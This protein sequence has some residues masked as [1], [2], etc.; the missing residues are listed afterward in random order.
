MKMER[1]AAMIKEIGGYFE[2]ESFS[3]HDFYCNLIALNTAR[4]ALAYVIKAKKISKVYIPRYLCDSVRTFLRLIS[5]DYELYSIDKNFRPI[6]STSLNQHECIYIV[7]Y[8]GQLNN[9]SIEELKITHGRI[10]LDNTHSFFQE[11]IEGIDTIYSCRKYFGVPDGAYL[12]TIEE[13]D[14]QLE[15][16]VSSNRLNH[17]IG[18]FEGGAYAFYD[19][20]RKV[21]STLGGESLKSMSRLTKNIL[22][23]IDYDFVAGQR[24]E[25]FNYLHGRLGQLNGL[26]ELRRDKG[27]F[28]YPL[29]LETGARIKKKLIDKR[30]YV[31]TLWPNVTRENKP[32]TL[33]Y[34]YAANII[35]LPCDQRYCVEDMKIIADTIFNILGVGDDAVGDDQKLR[36]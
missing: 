28:S 6:L 23:G 24:C 12:S 17:L 11:P 35:P 1:K 5:V 10:I 27:P 20:F 30:I 19:E 16:D 33:E 4:N 31:P 29:L 2:L 3:K 25:N 32:N 34:Y 22:R 36:K 7:N 9:K 18:R 14:E 13:V 8:Y 15:R 21:E 26:I